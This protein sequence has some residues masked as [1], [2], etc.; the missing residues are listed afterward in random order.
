MDQSDPI[1]IIATP[2]DNGKRLDR[3]LATASEV[4]LSRTRL[5][6]LIQDGSLTCD[7]VKLTDPSASVKSGACYEVTL[8]PVQ[9]ATPQPENIPL[10]IYFEDDHLIVLEKPAGMVVH[11][12][13]GAYEGTLVNA[14]LHHCGDSLSGIGGVARPG[15]VHRLDKDTSGVMMAAKSEKAHIK[16]S[17]MFAKHA[18][19]RRYHA[20]VWGLPPN[21][22]D[23]IDQPIGRSRYDRKKMTVTDTGKEA[24]THYQTLRDL[25][26][27]AALLEC[28]LETGRTHQI[29]VHLSAMGYGI[30]GDGV[31]GH[32]LRSAQMPDQI[33]RDV[34][35]GLR[36]FARQAL[37]AA[38]LGFEHPITKQ[39]MH[40]DSPL[41]ADMTGL[42]SQIEQGIKRRAKA[43]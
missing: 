17:K 14:L 34:L 20:L 30:I 37:H 25:P 5:K 6:A 9:D 31:Y 43:V 41:P 36:G 35:A 32:P 28:A 16:L 12:A 10:D 33:A 38:H 40:F 29:R 4:E 13:P 2:E 15:I 24:I 23:T 8:P 3:F 18:L 11:P 22:I 26:P 1:Q 39:Q 21:R 7:G 27:F 42:I 19:D